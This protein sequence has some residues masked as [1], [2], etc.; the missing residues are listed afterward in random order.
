MIEELMAHTLPLPRGLYCTS[1]S[2]EYFQ[3]HIQIELNFILN[4]QYNILQW[5]LY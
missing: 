1:D 5:H 4:K 3:S 2:T